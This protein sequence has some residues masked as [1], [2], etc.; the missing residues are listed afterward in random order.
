MT[1]FEPNTLVSFSRKKTTPPRKPVAHGHAVAPAVN[2]KTY[3]PEIPGTSAGWVERNTAILVVH[4]IGNQ[5]PL[6]TID[7]F[8]RGLICQYRKTFGDKLQLQ[9]KVKAKPADG[10]SNQWFDNVVRLT[11]EGSGTHIDLYEYYWANYTQDKATWS[12]LNSWLQGV[13]EGA[14]KFYRRNGD[15]GEVYKDK[16]PFFTHKG[17]FKAWKYRMFIYFISK[18]FILLN[19]ITTGILKLVSIIPV[20]GELAD[21]LLRSF[22]ETQVHTLTNLIGDIAVYNVVDPKSKF[23]CVRREILDGAVDALRYLIEAEECTDQQT[24]QQ[25]AYPAVVVAGHSLGSQVAYDAINKIN[26]LVNQGVIKNYEADGR[27]KSDKKKEQGIRKI[28]D[29][30]GRFITFGSPL[31]KIAFF[32]REYVEDKNYLRQ[33]V[34]T[35]YHGFKQR[36]WTM[37]ELHQAQV[38]KTRAGRNDADQADASNEYVPLAPSLKRLLDDI[39]WRNYFDGKDPVS[40]GLDYY[41]DVVNIDCAFETHGRKGFS[42]SYYWDFEHFYSDIIRQSITRRVV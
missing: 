39:E 27:Y 24:L 4:G 10:E 7:D 9:H 16:S 2:G 12:D 34:L 40:G 17:K 38:R 19:M 20:V 18:T 21:M 28:S 37:R 13:A 33:Q 1:P 32:L 31:D 15:L 42:H 25:L 29:Q 26:L 8:G 5:L 36:D 11:L 30:L 22:V 41:K 3:A 14:S 23:Y 6:E 35:A